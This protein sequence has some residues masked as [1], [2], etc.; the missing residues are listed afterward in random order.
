VFHF[1]SPDL[2][3]NG[4]WFDVKVFCTSPLIDPMFKDRFP[5]ELGI[6]A[7]VHCF[8]HG[9]VGIGMRQERFGCKTEEDLQNSF[10]NVLKAALVEKAIPYLAACTNL[11]ELIPKIRNRLYLGSA[12]RAVGREIE[13]RSILAEEK[14]RLLKVAAADDTVRLWLAF[15]DGP[16]NGSKGAPS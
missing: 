2:N 1:V 9:T 5:D 10:D 4:E 8:L 16:A 6:P 14:A 3:K 13:S 11:E 7:D 12:L 15:I